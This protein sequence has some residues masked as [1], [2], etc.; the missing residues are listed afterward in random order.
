MMVAGLVAAAAA[1]LYSLSPLTVWATALLALVL[2]AASREM[3]PR[4]RRWFLS[5]SLFALALRY[6]ALAA[7][8]VLGWNGAHSFRT[9]FGDDF[10]NIQRSLWLHHLVVGIPISSWDYFEAFQPIYGRSGY[11]YTLAFA[12][13]LA[14]PS[15]YAVLLINVVLHTCS[16]VLLYRLVRRAFGIMPAL[17]GALLLW[18]YTTLFAESV[19]ALKEPSQLF[20]T[21]VALSAIVAVVRSTSWRRRAAAAVVVPL[22][23]L[24]IWPLR[25]GALPIA[26]AGCAAGVA[27][28]VLTFRSWLAAT[29]GAL[30]IVS[31][32]TVMPPSLVMSLMRAP[33]KIAVRR[34]MGHVLTGG[35]SYKLLDDRVYFNYLEAK[36][37]PERDQVQTL[38]PGE[39]ARFL[40]RAAVE[41]II[42]PTPRRVNSLKW[43]A[44]MPQQIVWY[45]AVAFAVP[46]IFVGFR[47][48][49]LLT[50]M[51]C[52]LV[53]GG[54]AVTAPNS[55]NIG[56]LIRHRD[57]I[58]PFVFLLAGVGFVAVAEAAARQTRDAPPALVPET[59]CP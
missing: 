49:P 53:M 24:A 20:L 26:V 28:R 16:V 44:V 52:G 36:S 47:R 2:W 15:P 19:S 59:A 42:E 38:S 8:P 56:T 39:A 40:V 14:G 12:H 50:C 25:N 30:A 17:A 22:A 48:D 45:A 54:V 55:G 32:A 5:M 13:L 3:E 23:L 7:L 46:G 41:F 18:F 43:A 27:L 10:Y 9:Y 29:A 57:M 21:V 4:E 37:E 51:L 6:A 33:L 11:Q 35:D 1:V 58:S 34:H 31:L